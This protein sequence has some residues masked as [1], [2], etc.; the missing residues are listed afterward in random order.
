MSSPTV[1]PS[2]TYYLL[3]LSRDCDIYYT[4]DHTGAQFILMGIELLRKSS[5]RLSHHRN[6]GH[7]EEQLIQASGSTK[8]ERLPAEIGLA[9]G[10]EEEKEAEVFL[11]LRHRSRA[12]HAF[13][14]LLVSAFSLLEVF[15]LYCLNI[16]FVC[17]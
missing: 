5:S 4:V 17:F 12:C 13:P 14:S 16:G 10:V 8:T 7:W 2:G 3:C 1:L 15:P 11:H 9:K 6:G